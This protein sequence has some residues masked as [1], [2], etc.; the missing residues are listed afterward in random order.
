MPE[1]Q[2]HQAVLNV[3]F[4]GGNG[5]Y[6]DPVNYDSTDEQILGWAAEAVR[7]GYIPGVNRNLTADLTGFVVD[8]FPARDDKPNR[9]FVRPKTPFGGNTSYISEPATDPG[10]PIREYKPPVPVQ[11]VTKKEEPPKNIFQKF[12]D[13]ILDLLMRPKT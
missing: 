13:F 8:R 10:P 2:E 5:E 7:T 6:P 12:W 11:A 9:L 1:L 3:T 4:G